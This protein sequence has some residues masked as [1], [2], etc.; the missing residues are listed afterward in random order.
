MAVLIRLAAQSDAE[1]IAAIYR[2]YVETS[3]VSFEESAPDAAE[4]AGRMHDPLYPWLVVEEDGRIIG[5]AS[6]SPLRGRSAYR[7]S[8]ET[9]LYLKPGAQGRGI[10]RQLLSAHLELLERQGFVT[11]IAGISLPNAASVALHE[12]LGFVLS[13]IERGVGFKLGEW[14]DV[15]RWQRDLAPRTD[16]PGEPLH[17]ESVGSPE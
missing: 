8:V 3:Q 17:F 9:G 10:G 16:A 15:G 11:A 6:T 14:V 2:P 5:Y 4:M 13:G 12:K 7:W 1:A